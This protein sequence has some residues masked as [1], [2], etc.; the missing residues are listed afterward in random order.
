MERTNADF[1]DPVPW[2]LDDKCN[3]YEFV[4][5]R[6]WK[7]PRVAK[8]ATARE[9]IEAGEAFG[10]RFVVKQPDLHSSRGVYVLEKRNDGTFLDLMTARVLRA[11][12]VVPWGA[13]P[14][15]WIAEEYLPSTCRSAILPFDYKVYA[16]R[17]QVTHV[18]Q[19]DRSVRPVR[20]AAFDGAFLPLT[21]GQS[22]HLNGAAYRRQGHVI[23]LHAPGI[24]AMA[25]DLS[26]A[27][28]T[29]FVR[30]DCFDT[31]D[32]PAFGEFT[33]TP[34]AEDVGTIH[35]SGGAAAKI[36][37]ALAGSRVEAM[38]G[39]DVDLDAFYGEA[40]RHR[41]PVFTGDRGVL[42]L[43]AAN[44]IQTD[45]RYGRVLLQQI[46]PGKLG[47]HFALAARLLGFINGDHEQAARISADVRARHGFLA[48]A[49]RA[50]EFAE[51]ARNFEKQ[52]A[53]ALKAPQ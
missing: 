30:V 26:A 24:L 4:R 50:E 27:I 14:D 5:A 12:D 11:A 32:G 51:I 7:V 52:L 33:F 6:G 40:V 53:E 3:A 21:F 43:A 17:G 41:G 22:L 18:M 31:P 25:R 16:F 15:H 10:A 38:S 23:P 8:C 2:D 49:R 9:A 34:G 42:A 36:D 37:R 48:S 28:D 29:A 46:P 47:A 13:P 39:F 19:M 20:V 45:V 44:A 35:Y 1:G